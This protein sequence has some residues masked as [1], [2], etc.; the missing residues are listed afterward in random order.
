[1]DHKKEDDDDFKRW[2]NNLNSINKGVTSDLGPTATSKPMWKKEQTKADP[3][4][5][6]GSLA[7]S[8]IVQSAMWAIAKARHAKWS[9]PG[10]VRPYKKL[11]VACRLQHATTGGLAVLFASNQ[12]EVPTDEE[13][14]SSISRKLEKA[15]L[16]PTSMNWVQAPL[17]FQ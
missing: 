17:C 10:S 16:G 14:I 12:P 15:Y 7:L 2:R 1:M 9:S 8:M 3:D 6:P 13:N 4:R 5:P 11:C